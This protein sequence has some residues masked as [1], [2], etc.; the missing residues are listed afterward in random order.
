MTAMAQALRTALLDF[1]WQGLAVAFLLWVALFLLRKRRPQARYAAACA[2]LAVLAAMPVA[3]AWLAWRAPSAAAAGAQPDGPQWALAVLTTARSGAV[4][5][6]WVARLEPWAL[7]LWSAGV[8]FFSLR[9]VWGCRRVSAM[10]RRG[11]PAEAEILATVAGLAARMGLS[12]PVRVLTAALPDGPS[13]AGWMRP[14][15][16]LPP[17]ALLGLTPQQ[18]EAVLAHELAHIRRYD[19]L[20]NAVQTLVETL[21]FYHPAV[22][23]ASARIRAERELCCDDMAVRACGDPLCFARALARLERLRVMTPAAALGSTGGPL[24]YRVQRLVGANHQEC[25]PSKLAGILAFSLGL[26]CLALNVHWARGQERPPIGYAVTVNPNQEGDAAGV[27][28]DLGGSAVLHRASVAYPESA[29]NSGIQGT[30]AVQVT[31]DATGN[32][33]DAHVIS[34]PVE[35]RKAVMSSVFDWHFA[36]DAAGTTRVVNVSFQKAAADAAPRENRVLIGSRK[37]AGGNAAGTLELQAAPAN[38]PHVRELQERIAQQRASL[39]SSDGNDAQARAEIARLEAVLVKT[40]QTPP[41]ADGPESAQVRELQERLEQQRAVLASPEGDNA[42]VREQI[43]RNTAELARSLENSELTQRQREEREAESRDRFN[44][45]TSG[46]T[47]TAIVTAGLSESAKSD[48][49]SRLPV[50]IGDTL[51]DDS[52]TQIAAAVR[53]YDEHLEFGVIPAENN[54]ATVR[55]VVRGFGRM[56]EPVRK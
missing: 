17:A 33:S 39:A 12:R 21:L 7:P 38:S 32:V 24:M 6:D 4:A 54:G 56:L 49:L 51:A 52:V 30:V 28:V 34:G 11:R 19:H 53:S 3:T 55:I 44:M 26:A 47:V 8:L 42:E 37:P 16:L 43:A 14:V 36:P 29:R 45:R 5:R 20:V 15:L 13:V 1:V 2:A 46:R 23:W 27:A 22:W 18:L 50:H 41:S 9:L 35:L 10:R 25:A 40:E 48:L 31:L